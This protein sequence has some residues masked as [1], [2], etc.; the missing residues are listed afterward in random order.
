MKKFV[1]GLGSGRCGTGSLARVLQKNGFNT[2]HE[3][4]FMPWSID[5][6]DSFK[7][8]AYMYHREEDRVADVGYYWVNYVDQ[9]FK[10]TYKPKM[11]C[12]KRGRQEVIDSW[13]NYK[14]GV[15]YWTSPASKHWNSGSPLKPGYVNNGD[16]FSQR[17]RQFPKYDLP[18][19]EAIGEYWDEYY[20]IAE[21]QQAK[22][23]E[24]LRIYD[25]DYVL[26]T[27]DGQREM[28]KFIDVEEPVVS[29]NLKY[30]EQLKD[31]SCEKQ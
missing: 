21:Y 11:V 23:P 16:L 3:A 24:I 20:R 14:H 5:K 1:F 9:A 8:L 31:E 15:N 29:L 13:M 12:L 30:H 27:E 22:Y 6:H 7:A 26:N 18:K 2:S 25:M 28:F 19:A 17:I 10:Y 4:F